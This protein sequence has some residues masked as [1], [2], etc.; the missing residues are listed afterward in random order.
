MSGDSYTA[1][2]AKR[3]GSVLEITLNRPD[4][5]NALDET[6]IAELTRCVSSASGNARALVL[7]GAGESFCAG[8]DLNW[9]ARAAAYSHEE[10]LE[11]ARRL[12]R[13]L[14][15][16]AHFPGVT[17]SV[18][19]G[20]AIGG[21]A[22]I[23]AA[24]DITIAAYDSWFMFSEVRLG[25]VPAIIAPYVVEKI[26]IGAAR[27]LF[28]TGERL[29]GTRAKDIGLVQHLSP[30]SEAAE[31]FVQDKL[32]LVLEAGPEAVAAAKCLLRE[33]ANRPPEQVNEVT[34]ACI[35]AARAGA[36]GQEGMMAFLE[37]RKPAFA[38]PPP[39]RVGSD[40]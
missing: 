7:R 9:M 18:V 4:V 26:G 5:R 30:D 39:E 31:R 27:A 1:L 6:L 25:L 19:N 11:D 35:A 21:G 22:G 36:E 37:K 32:K 15:A 29:N 24:C 20:A 16:L 34:V 14:A 8:A 23:A 2:L 38:E 28:V 33:I 3:S 13:M 12:Q 10:N 40:G 17:I